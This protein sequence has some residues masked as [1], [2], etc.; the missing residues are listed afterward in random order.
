MVR[1]LTQRRVKA[2]T[3]EEEEEEVGFSLA[4]LQ[5]CLMSRLK[6]G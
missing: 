2:L 4:T 6:T 5:Q 1:L 3:E